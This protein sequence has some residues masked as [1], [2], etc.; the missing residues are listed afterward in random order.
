[1]L[2][3]EEL[4]NLIERPELLSAADVARATRKLLLFV[5]EGMEMMD[6]A[7]G[8]VHT[9]LE[10]LEKTPNA[11]TVEGGERAPQQA[12]ADG[13]WQPKYRE[14]YWLVWADGSV[15]QDSYRWEG[16]ALDGGRYA[17]GRVFPT[18]EAAEKF[19]RRERLMATLFRMATGKQGDVGWC[20]V[21]R[22][23]YLECE[24]WGSGVD[25]P[26]VPRFAS[27]EEVLA[28]IDKYGDEI[29]ELL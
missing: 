23:G 16:Y 8:V 2:T 17:Q 9:R 25:V 10:A 28:A 29:R 3:D 14:N 5:L 4:T 19:A 15:R 27:R 21:R 1:M 13:P 26:G 22:S 20:I 11:E 7:F 6:D 18:Y 24:I 12:A